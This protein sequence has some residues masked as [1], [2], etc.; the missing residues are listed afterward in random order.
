MADRN[1]KRADGWAFA[2]GTLPVS[3]LQDCRRSAPMRALAWSYAAPRWLR[4]KVTPLSLLA[5]L[6]SAAAVPAIAQT[7]PN[8]SG[9]IGPLIVTE[10]KRRPVQR[11]EANAGRPRVHARVA[12]RTRTSARK[13]VPAPGPVPV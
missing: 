9:T 7:A 10:P 11:V 8:D 2:V 13:P 6:S 3:H 5:L 4:S 1:G 12:S